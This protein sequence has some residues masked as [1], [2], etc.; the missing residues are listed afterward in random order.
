MRALR[1]ERERVRESRI[2]LGK[3]NLRAFGVTEGPVHPVGCCCGQKTRKVHNTAALVRA[4]S[5]FLL[6]CGYDPETGWRVL[7]PEF[8]APVDEAAQH[9]VD[10]IQTIKD[11]GELPRW[12]APKWSKG[13]YKWLERAPGA[14]S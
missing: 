1:H 2:I 4:A 10:A 9:L 6:E 11:T 13:D 7:L 5:R 8:A 14:S 12:K 3:K